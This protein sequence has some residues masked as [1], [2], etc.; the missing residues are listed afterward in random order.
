MIVEPEPSGDTT[1]AAP[2][3]EVVP[4]SPSSPCTAFGRPRNFLGNQYVYGV[5]SQRARGLSIGINLTPDKRCNFDCVYCEINR[6]EPGSPGPIQISV[7]TAE[8]AGLLERVRE[9]TLA[10][11]PW[12]RNVPEE[13]LELRE[14]ALSGDGEPTLCPQFAEVMEAVIYF[15]ARGIFPFK[16]VLITNTTGLN[17]PEVQNGL[18]LM[19]ARDEVWVKLDAG[20]QAWM[21]RVNAPDI[22]LPCVLENILTLGRKRPVVI[23][24]LFPSLLGEG[25]PVTEIEEYAQRL[26]ELK[27]AGA[28]IAQVQIYSAHRPP[29]RSDCTHLPLKDLSFIA[30]RVREIA[31]LRAEIF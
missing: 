5:V 31:G 3:G 2:A 13:L 20:T 8:L 16:I 19:T 17:R 28:D 15:R 25:P 12:F 4:V 7:L 29:H 10:E 1:S 24:S 22:S 30:R 23:Q 21:D 11:L 14:V 27:Q 9:K 18:R 26:L 6:D